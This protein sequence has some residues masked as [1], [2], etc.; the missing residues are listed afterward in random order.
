MTEVDRTGQSTP[1]AQPALTR[2]L[3]ETPGP[4]ATLGR[5][6][7]S[8][9]YQPASYFEP[10]DLT[11]LFPRP[12][13]IEVELGSGDGS[14][15]VQSA[16]AH[17]ATNYLGVE[18]LLGRLRKIDRKGQRARLDNLCL[19]RVE[20]AYFLEYLLPPRSTRVLHVYFPDPWP[21]RKHRKNRLINAR[22]PEL[23]CRVLEPGGTVY[24]RTD[25]PDYFGQMTAVFRASASFR[26]VPTPSGLADLRTDFETDFHA[27]G[28]QTLSAAY[29]LS[30]L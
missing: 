26:E 12:N 27:R 11:R 16:Q 20:A 6:Q 22:F 8:L 19:I 2:P 3:T 13:P 24:L 9:I 28:V 17:P 14:F 15:L 30:S 7:P 29:Q 21:K 18:R 23:S 25:D 5:A 10:L 4:S 1:I